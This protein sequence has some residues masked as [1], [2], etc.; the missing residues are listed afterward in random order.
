MVR[1]KRSVVARE[2]HKK[3]LKR[4]SGY[5]GARSRVYRVAKQS[6]IK[7]GQYAYCDRKLKKRFFRSMWV[8]RINAAVRLYKMS[9]STFINKVKNVV[10][11][12]KKSLAAIALHDKE[13]FKNL[14][15]RVRKGY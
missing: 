1:V 6:V 7:A 13:Y 8:M 4:A 15:E 12:N 14:V 5:Y 9:Y 10:A 11:L 2:R 3:V